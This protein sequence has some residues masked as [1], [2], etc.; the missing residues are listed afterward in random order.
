MLFL[1]LLIQA[2]SAVMFQK[3]TMAAAITISTSLLLVACGG[4]NGDNNGAVVGSSTTSTGALQG[5]PTKTAS[6][7]A[8]QFNGALLSS[9]TGTQL[10]QATGTPKC[11][12]SVSH[13]EYTTTGAAGEST[14]ASGAV[15]VPSGSDPA[16]SGKRP[17][18]LYAHG[19]T[20]SKGFNMA[21][22][23]DP[24]NAAAGETTLV[25]ATFAAQGYIV[26]APNYA[27][28]DTSALTYHPYVNYK[29][30]S[31]EMI[32][33]LKAGRAA[34]PAATD[35]GKLF[36]TGYSEGGYVAMATLK[37]M[38][39]AHI[40]V[41]AGAP[42]SGPYSLEAYGDAVFY[43]NTPIGGTVFAPLLTAGYQKA[44]GNIYNVTS[45][46]Y[47]STY[48]ANIDTLLPS[49]LSFNDLF[50]TGKLP[51]TALFQSAPTGSPLLDALSPKDP[52]FSFGFAPS[53][54]LINTSYRAAYLADAQAH[55][56]GAVPALTSS[57]LPAAA[58]ANTLRQAFKLND[59]RGYI[60]SMPV[61]MCGGNQDP[62]VFFAPNAQLM[63]GIMGNVAA[64]GAPVAFALLDVDATNAGK[65]GFSSA[66]LGATVN[67]AMTTASNQL[68]GA[69]G[70]SL[71][72]LVNATQSNPTVLAGAKAAGNAAA[73]QV[74][75]S[76][77]T[78]A[79]AQAAAQAAGVAYVT[80][81]VKAAV[82]TTYH[83]G[84]VPPVCTIAART[85]FQQ[86]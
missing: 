26:I 62:T 5:T 4:S 68:M 58:P 74:L 28:Y 30:Q 12:I 27:G 2:R 56:D 43:G 48:A 15:M 8:A 18:V 53:N 42:M 86:Y 45:D 85:F 76:G 80:A 35:S 31:Q 10:V 36:V 47:T 54:Y 51:Q 57:P 34:L 33:A 40:P 11:D 61:L 22:L 78:L 19:T 73:Q 64:A 70:S 20:T 59:L 39:V 9:A 66:G 65:V 75:A 82:A 25:A 13:I 71:Q 84:L 63:A 55:P 41:A 60:P 72:A 69:F 50:I 37:A 23:T 38:D 3:T 21:A 7:T 24:T 46:A 14:T 17:V 79:A 16:C 49:T 81:A 1:A 77:G 67:G 29:Q 6:L 44:Y 83:G 32:D 52:R